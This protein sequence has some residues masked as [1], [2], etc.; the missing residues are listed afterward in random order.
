MKNLVF[1]KLAF[2]HPFVRS[3]P[4]IGLKSHSDVLI[5]LLS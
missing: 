1:N 2:F 5:K 4:V 3:K